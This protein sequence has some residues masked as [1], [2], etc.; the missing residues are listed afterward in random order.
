[1]NF[2]IHS[3]MY[4]YYA[5][6]ALQYRIPRIIS[7]II[8][9]GQITQMVFGF[10][11]NY[12]SFERNITGVPC[13]MTLASASTGLALYSIFFLMFL[14]FFI[15]AYLFRPQVNRIVFFN[16]NEKKIQWYVDMM[17]NRIWKKTFTSNHSYFCFP[18]FWLFKTCQI[19]LNI[20]KFN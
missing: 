5:L 10:I 2:A 4:S 12:I 8:T 19:F 17:W 15:K 6:R 16:N 20:I 3:L 9:F 18:N 14:N 7:M 13:D 11:I 1:M